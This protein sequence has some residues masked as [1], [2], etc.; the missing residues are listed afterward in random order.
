MGKYYLAYR[1]CLQLF[2]NICWMRPR[3]APQRKT[4]SCTAHYGTPR[5]NPSPSFPG[6]LLPS[7]PP[8]IC[9]AHSKEHQPD[10]K[11]QVAPFQ[12]QV[13]APS[14]GYRIPWDRLSTS[15]ALSSSLTGFPTG[16][17]RDPRPPWMP[18]SLCPRPWACA[19][20]APGTASAACSGRPSFRDGLLFPL[21]LWLSLARPLQ[22]VSRPLV[23]LHS[24]LK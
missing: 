3:D 6:V 12:G 17:G 8:W 4:P 22:V 2:K 16:W 20:P 10:L 21:S 14:L 13:Q 19:V 15:P 18:G 24:A 7:L 23:C 9:S 11:H 5:S 1:I